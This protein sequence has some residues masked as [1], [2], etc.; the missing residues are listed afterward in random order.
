MDSV[1]NEDVL[2]RASTKRSL[3]KDIRGRH[4]AFLGHVKI[5]KAMEH[6]VA[7]GKIERKRRRGRQRENLFDNLRD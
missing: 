6:R 4:S 1:T 2:K 7:T 5:Q 3:M